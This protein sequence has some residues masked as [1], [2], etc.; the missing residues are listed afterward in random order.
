MWTPSNLSS[1]IRSSHQIYGAVAIKP[2]GTWEALA[3]WLEWRTQDGSGQFYDPRA[4]QGMVRG[5]AK[6]P[7]EIVEGVFPPILRRK[8]FKKS[9]RSLLLIVRTKNRQ[10]QKHKDA[11]DRAR[12]NALCVRWLNVDM[13]WW[14]PAEC[15]DQVHRLSCSG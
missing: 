8:K 15:V 12:T 6:E 11:L 2:K 14:S 7:K 10:A 3:T 9:Y 1:M 4:Q 5:G 13:H